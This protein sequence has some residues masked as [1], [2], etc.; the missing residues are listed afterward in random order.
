MKVPETVIINTEQQLKET[1]RETEEL[2]LNIIN[3]ESELERMK[4][5]FDRSVEEQADLVIFLK[6]ANNEREDLNN[7]YI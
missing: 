2:R 6:R 5:K 7:E 4:A 3:A 1:Q